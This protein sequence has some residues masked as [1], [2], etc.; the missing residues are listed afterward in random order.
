VIVVVKFLLRVINL[1]QALV[2]VVV[3]TVVLVV[4]ARAGGR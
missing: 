3:V 2:V 4:E 1:G